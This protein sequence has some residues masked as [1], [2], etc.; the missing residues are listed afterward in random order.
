M[1]PRR[2]SAQAMRGLGVLSILQVQIDSKQKSVTGFKI[3]H[4][5]VLLHISRKSGRVGLSW[6]NLK[7]HCLHKCIS[8]LI[9]PVRAKYTGACA[10]ALLALQAVVND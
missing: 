3:P 10:G 1:G 9:A 6:F 2:R 8:K 7:D 4:V 5:G